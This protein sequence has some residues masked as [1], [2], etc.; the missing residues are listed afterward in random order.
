MRNLIWL[1]FLA[2]AVGGGMISPPASAQE[3]TTYTYDALGRLV[4]VRADGN[5]DRQ[6][7]AAYDYDEAGNRTVVRTTGESS[8]GGGNSDG[9]VVGSRQRLVVT[10]IGA[11]VPIFYRE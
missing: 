7:T 8:G 11:Y 3:T 6:R 5:P 10:P 4:A 9:A 2:G 1:S